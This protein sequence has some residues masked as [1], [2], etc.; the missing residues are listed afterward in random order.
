MKTRPWILSFFLAS[1]ALVW[2]A[3][4][5]HGSAVLRTERCLECHNVLG[6]GS[7][8]ARTAPDLGQRLVS[9][10]TVPALASELWNHTPSMLA[11]MSSRAMAQPIPSEADWEDVFMYLY[12]LQFFDRPAVA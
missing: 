12:S 4:A 3:D 6:E 5:Q 10:Y 2:A 8:K 7:S 1:T 9:A 11:Q